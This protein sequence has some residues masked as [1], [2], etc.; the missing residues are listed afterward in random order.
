M[1]DLVPMADRDPRFPTRCRYARA[2]LSSDHTT[3][4]KLLMSPLEDVGDIQYIIELALHIREPRVFPRPAVSDPSDKIDM[5]PASPPRQSRPKKS[6]TGWMSNSSV[7]PKALSRTSSSSPSAAVPSARLPQ[8]PAAVAAVAATADGQQ[9]R[10][11]SPPSSGADV[12]VSVSPPTGLLRANDALQQKVQGLKNANK[13]FGAKLQ[14]HLEQLQ[15]E[16]LATDRL[17]NDDV[18]YLALAGMKE[19]KDV[20]QG[21]ISPTTMLKQ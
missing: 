11:I 4:L 16:L 1:V 20:L 15:D 19:V 17:P 18:I 2:D 5:T 6:L 12:S 8:P 7:P 14:L 3:V 10:S 21:R 9:A 13:V